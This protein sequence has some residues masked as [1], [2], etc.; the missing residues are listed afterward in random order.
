MGIPRIA[1]RTK[2]PT[3][4]A[5]VFPTAEIMAEPVDE[6]FDDRDY[7][8]EICDASGP[9]DIFPEPVHDFFDADDDDYPEPPLSGADGYTV[10]PDDD[11]D[12]PI[13]AEPL[14]PPPRPPTTY[15]DPPNPLRRGVPPTVRMRR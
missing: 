4:Q 3:A 6:F 1:K 9:A 10:S 7:V 5:T 15:L 13:L 2:T 12:R 11:D 14:Q 8:G